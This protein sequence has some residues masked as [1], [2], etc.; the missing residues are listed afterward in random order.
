VS[1]APAP[2]SPS[3]SPSSSPPLLK[4]DR[5][6]LRFRGLVAVSDVSL[7]VQAGEIFAVI[8]PNGAGKTSLFNAI[9]GIYQP[10]SGTVS[11][12]GRDL[13]SPL[14]RSQAL[15]WILVGLLTGVALF[16]L[17]A[18]VNVMW[19][20]V[21]KQNYRSTQQKFHG[22]QAIS[23]FGD[24]LAAHPRIEQR[25]G[26]FFVT[27][28]DGRTPYGSSRSE[29]EAR[30]RQRAVLKMAKV[31]PSRA[32]IV[33]QGEELVLRYDGEVLDRAATRDQIDAR[34]AAAREADDAAARARRRRGLAFLLGF[35]LGTAGSYAVWRQ[36]RR[37]PSSVAARGIART[38][39]NIRLF[40]DM[41]VEENVLVGM[42]HLV[43][44]PSGRW[45]RRLV[46][47]AVPLGLATI[48]VLL[49]GAFR[50]NVGGPA[51]WT[52]LLF[53]LIGG[54]GAY[55]IRVGRLG[56]FSRR[57]LAAETAARAEA[58]TLLALVGL[59][60]KK[61]A[62]AKNLAYGDQRRLE[63][64]RGLATRARLLLLDE[65]AAGMNPSETVDLMKLIRSIRDRGVTILLI[66][67]HMRVVMGIS[68]RIA[69][70]E[71]GQKIAEGP[72]EKIRADP[73][74]IEAYLGKEETAT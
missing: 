67:H 29:T 55:L 43:A 27:T 39:Q 10:T 64:A 11:F 22:R 60:D 12:D 59:D 20:A 21:I 19:A 31:D 35:L 13:R 73:R 42:R 65:P 57:T 53:L 48:L 24:Y 45:R 30:Q 41:T 15:R 34:L 36:T 18:D 68:D 5:L 52:A 8:G 56:A 46:D 70:L 26:R 9:T 4:V 61:N 17:A 54:L 51:L 69:V 23:D 72:P 37:T 33:Q 47:H 40:Q 50:W 44:P 6:T 49:V 32:E 62:S 74:V 3:P 16:L 71:Y 25:S 7:A 58:H 28:F 1:A 66:E 2:S 38:F 14:Q 63:I